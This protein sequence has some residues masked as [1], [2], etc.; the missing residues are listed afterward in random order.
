MFVQRILKI[1]L[2]FGFRTKYIGSINEEILIQLNR[3]YHLVK[4]LELLPESLKAESLKDSLID[5]LK[6]HFSRENHCHALLILDDVC[7]SKIIETFNFECKTLV[8]TADRS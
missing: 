8:I 5:F 1:C 6:H 7:D 3:L 2:T 4:N